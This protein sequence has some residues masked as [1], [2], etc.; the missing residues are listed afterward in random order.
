MDIARSISG[1]ELWLVPHA[2]H[3][4]P[5]ENV[6]EFNLRLLKFLNDHNI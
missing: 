6:A 5:Q 2:R 1:A 4:L 3:M